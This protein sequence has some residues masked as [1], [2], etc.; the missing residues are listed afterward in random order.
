MENYKLKNGKMKNYEKTKNFPKTSKTTPERP[1]THLKR[2]ASKNHVLFFR[3]YAFTMFWAAVLFKNIGKSLNK[4]C[5]SQ[6]NNQN[7]LE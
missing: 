1:G 3:N 7:V 6:Q 2:R 5:F 4:P